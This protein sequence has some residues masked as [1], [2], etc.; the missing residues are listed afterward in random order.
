MT[1]A[2]AGA[3]ACGK[4]LEIAPD[5]AGTDGASSSD[6]TPGADAPA[7]DPDGGVP[8]VLVGDIKVTLEP[9]VVDVLAGA[10]GTKFTVKVERPAND[11][12]PVNISYVVPSQLVIPVIPPL[13]GP[14]AST[15]VTAL[16]T[17]APRRLEM[18]V[19]V[20]TGTAAATLKL[21]IRVAQEYRAE[22]TTFFMTADAQTYSIAAWGAGGGANKGGGGGFVAGDVSVAAGA[23]VIVVVGSP[24][25]DSLTAGTPGGGSGGDSPSELNGGGGGGYSGVFVG[26]TVSIG[27]AGIVAGAG[28]GGAESAMVIQRG[29]GGGSTSSD[30]AESGGGT[31]GGGGASATAGGTGGGGTAARAGGPLLGGSGLAGDPAG[32]GG[33]GGYFGGGGGGGACG[34]GGGA[35]LIPAGGTG[36]GGTKFVAANNGDARRLLAGNP[37]KPGAVLVVPK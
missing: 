25:N 20:D 28:G 9:A 36:L 31:C 12:T 13:L 4:A 3:L 21:V 22:G 34:G 16:S 37:G 26:P 30:P 23:N 1:A 11:A 10:M 5:D 6:A 18:D 33:G 24:G 19:H 7:G 2:C 8:T 17:A 14:S 27:S 29:G 15:D 35:S 32:G